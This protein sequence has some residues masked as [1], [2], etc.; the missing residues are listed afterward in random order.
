MKMDE[1]EAKRQLQ[2]AE[3]IAKAVDAAE[4]EINAHARKLNSEK[5]KQADQEAKAQEE[6]QKKEKVSICHLRGLLGLFPPKTAFI[7]HLNVCA[8]AVHLLG[9]VIFEEL[10]DFLLLLR[11]ARGVRAVTTLMSDQP[12]VTKEHSLVLCVLCPKSTVL[13]HD[14]PIGGEG[15]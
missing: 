5:K 3:S 7:V 1:A 15:L 9:P 11:H 13:T 14:V 8:V 2:Y 4:S 10:C 12:A 6:E